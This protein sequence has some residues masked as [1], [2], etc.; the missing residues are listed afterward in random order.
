MLKRFE[1]PT[2][3]LVAVEGKMTADVAAADTKLDAVVPLR[4]I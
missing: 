3:F 1:I 2:S 4:T